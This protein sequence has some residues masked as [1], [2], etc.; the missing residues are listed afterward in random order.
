MH[1]VFVF[2]I[3]WGKGISLLA[4]FWG[5]VSLIF[6]H[7]VS[8]VENYLMKQ[9]YKNVNIIDL[10]VLPYKRVFILHI[11]VMFSAFVVLILSWNILSVVML[12]FLKIVVDVFAHKIGH[13]KLQKIK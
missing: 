8:Y 6:S 4:L 7:G 10:M 3:F 2:S 11:V 1:G 12:V 9:E 13:L 5:F